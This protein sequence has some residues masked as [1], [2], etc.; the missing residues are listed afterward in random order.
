MFPFASPLRK[1]P[2]LRRRLALVL[3]AAED[4]I[5]QANVEE[6]V[7]FLK[8]T[9]RQ[10]PFEDA[11]AIYFR[12]V[13][14]PPRI[15]QAVTIHTLSRLSEGP[16]VE[17]LLEDTPAAPPGGVHGLARRLRGRRQESLRREVDEAATRAR[18]RVRG[19]YLDGATRAVEALREVVPATEAVQYFIDAL[20][21]GRGWGELVFHEVM[22]MEWAEAP[23]ELGAGPSQEAPGVADT[24]HP[25][26]PGAG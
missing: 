11:L 12:L 3:A 25:P 18:T 19:S 9:E 26:E 5:V 14:V 20:Q 24:I 4:L 22:G 6:A 1:S 15:R 2:E 8:E 23:R 10:L 21:I 17:E 7:S 13:G 16:E